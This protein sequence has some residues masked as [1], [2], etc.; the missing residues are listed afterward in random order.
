M[1]G[2]PIDIIRYIHNMSIQDNPSFDQ[3]FI[4]RT[5]CK[6]WLSLYPKDVLSYPKKENFYDILHNYKIMKINNDLYVEHLMLTLKCIPTTKMNMTTKNILTRLETQESF[7]KIVT[8]LKLNLTLDDIIE[9]AMLPVIELF[10][11]TILINKLM[12]TNCFINKAQYYSMMEWMIDTQIVDI[13][14][15]ISTSWYKHVFSVNTYTD[16]IRVF[17]NITEFI[18]L[19]RNVLHNIICYYINE[20]KLWNLIE[21]I[22]QNSYG[23][24]DHN[25][26]DLLNKSNKHDLMKQENCVCDRSESKI[27]I[28]KRKTDF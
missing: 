18:N 28:K 5:I 17:K 12:R 1:E 23:Y 25:I 10:K 4:L 9:G 13:D 19:D 24:S 8:K 11:P 15:L 6:R 14:L 26:C 16:P 2:L 20:N 21:H 7:L 27:T 22:L 3:R